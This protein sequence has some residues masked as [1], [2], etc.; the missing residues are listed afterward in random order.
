MLKLKLQRTIGAS[1]ASLS[2]A[3]AGLSSLPSSANAQVDQVERILNH[4]NCYQVLQSPPNFAIALLQDQFDLLDQQLD[5]AFVFGATQFCNPVRKVT[6]A[7]NETP[8]VNPFNHLTFY[9]MLDFPNGPER[10]V[11]INNQFGE[12]RMR[13]LPWAFF[14][15]VPTEK[16]REGPP[17][18]LDHFKCYIAQ[19]EA[20]NQNV[21][22]FDQFFPF[23]NGLGTAVLEP[24]LLCNPTRKQHAGNEIGV[25]EPEAH[26][27]CYA[28]KPT[29]FQQDI[30]IDNQFVEAAPMQIGQ[31]QSLCVPSLKRIVGNRLP[32]LVIRLPN[33]ARV[34]CPGG[35]GTCTQEMDFV[36]TELNGVA[37]NQA[38]RVQITN[39]LGQT[40]T[41]ILPGIAAGGSVPG[42]ATLGPPGDNCYN[43]NCSTRGAVDVQ[44][45]D[46]LILE[47]DETN[48]TA[49]REDM[50]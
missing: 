16:N 10:Q 43:P 29:R 2:L 40:Q 7:G 48:N 38:F 39:E 27:A 41:V 24:Q 12:Q 14:L 19:G 17:E 35:G 46:G 15:G 4:F 33:P 50:G 5:L 30:R 20:V 34:L 45:F 21:R 13:V 6:E 36:V 22:L 1:I 44:L 28:T 8:I 32:D 37:V 11:V 23:P 9:F 3:F 18:K 26:L 31:A 47:S 25:N 42:T 49:N